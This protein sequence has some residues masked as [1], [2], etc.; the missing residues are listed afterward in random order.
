MIRGFLGFEV[1][2][3][4]LAGAGGVEGVAGE[5]P[6][7]EGSS[8]IIREGKEESERPNGGYRLRQSTHWY[9]R[10]ACVIPWL[11]RWM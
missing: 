9:R 2:Y 10:Y 11:G 1:L 4:H 6:G 8:G 3:F 5:G 7:A